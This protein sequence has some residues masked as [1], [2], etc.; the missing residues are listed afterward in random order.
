MP[1]S[2]E[3]YGPGSGL[4]PNFR[5]TLGSFFGGKLDTPPIAPTGCAPSLSLSVGELRSEGSSPAVAM[6]ACAFFAGEVVGVDSAVL[7]FLSRRTLVGAGTAAFA[8][9]VDAARIAAPA[10]SIEPKISPVRSTQASLV[11]P[12]PEGRPFR[13]FLT[14]FST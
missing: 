14:N 4:G 2:T 13:L 7:V 6:G 3:L 1:E 9:R 12:T 10:V 8:R 5:M 11:V